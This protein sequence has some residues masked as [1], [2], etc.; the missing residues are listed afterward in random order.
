MELAID[1]STDTASIAV[2]SKGDLIAE[3]TWRTG[4]NHTTELMPNLVAL[5]R[6]AGLALN[7]IDALIVATGPG[8]FNGLRVGMS[9][10]KGLAFGLSARLV[11]IGSL[12]VTAFP[13]SG[14]GLPVCAVMNAGRGDIAAAVFQVA[15]G[16]WLRVVEEHVTTLDDLLARIECE[17]LFCGTLSPEAVSRIRERLGE[18]ALFAAGAG[19]PRRAG[20]LAELG[21][22]R[23]SKG[24]CDDASTLQPLYLKRPAVTMSPKW[25]YQG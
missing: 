24:D 16:R 14:A 23:L 18:K 4:Q 13:H 19:A 17:T 12:E 6:Q 3:L 5:L 10:A 25:R 11:G 8:T 1:T 15:G 7:D 9:V 22:R 20:Y 21:W 2:A